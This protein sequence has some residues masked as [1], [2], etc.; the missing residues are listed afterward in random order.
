MAKTLPKGTE[1]RCPR[2]RH[3]VGVLKK[4]LLA[5]SIVSLYAIE[6]TEGQERVVGE[7]ACCKVCD[8]QYLVQGNLHTAEG[9]KPFNPQLEPVAHK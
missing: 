8:S 1:I 5:G 4:D 6:F 3:L 2:K 9:W 7:K